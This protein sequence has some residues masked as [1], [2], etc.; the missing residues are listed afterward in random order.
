MV[1]KISGKNKMMS[2][3]V[4]KFIE[5][6]INLVLLNLRYFCFNWTLEIGYYVEKVIKVFRDLQAVVY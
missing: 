6:N 1:L 5:N 2:V 3:V 4:S